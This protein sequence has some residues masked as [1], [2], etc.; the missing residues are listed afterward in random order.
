MLILRIHGGARLVQDDN[1]AFLKDRPRDADPL[2][3]SPGEIDSLRPDQSVLPLPE[4]VQDAVAARKV[5]G[6]QNLLPLR[7]PPGGLTLS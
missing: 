4:F 1:A 2:L 7:I 6:L 5:Q 3:L